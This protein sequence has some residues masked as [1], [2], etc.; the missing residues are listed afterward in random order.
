MRAC[1]RLLVV[2]AIAIAAATTSAA[3]AEAA[4]TVQHYANCT[5]VHHAYTG[6]IAKQGVTTNTV[7]SHGSVTHRALKGRVLHSTAMYAANRKLDRDK[8]GI[9][10][11]KS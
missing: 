11:E 7:R 5:A 3:P 10:C 8:D 9:A 6:G 1:S 4:A 2:V